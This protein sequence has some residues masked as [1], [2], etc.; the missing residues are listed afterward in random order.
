MSQAASCQ[1]WSHWGTEVTLG[2]FFLTVSQGEG[3][4]KK[5][6][7][8]DRWTGL[9]PGE[10]CRLQWGVWVLGNTALQ[11]VTMISSEVAHGMEPVWLPRLVL[12]A[13]CRGRCDL[14]LLWER[15]PYFYG[16]RLLLGPELNA[17]NLRCKCWIS[18]L[19]YYL[20]YPSS[21]LLLGVWLLGQ[22]WWHPTKMP[23]KKVISSLCFQEKHPC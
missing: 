4:G 2:T 12:H 13:V 3:R 15:L 1:Y 22:T 14:S 19:F 20:A 18:P 21:H 5:E 10:F 7:Q 23:R 16:F 9:P 11:A 6:L 8:V 17:L